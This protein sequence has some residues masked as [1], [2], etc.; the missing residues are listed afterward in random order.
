MNKTSHCYSTDTQRQFILADADSFFASCERVF[1]PSLANK[2]IVV[3][4]NNDG[5]VVAR[6]LEAKN[7]GIPRGIPWFKIREQAAH[8][9]V[10]ARSSNYELYASLSTRMMH[11]MN[12]FLP[13][14]HVY[15][16]DECFFEAHECE[17]EL[18]RISGRMQNAV[19]KGLGLP[20]SIS[21]APTLTLTKI[22][23]HWAKRT[24]GTRTITTWNQAVDFDKNFLEHIDVAH[25]WGVGRHL[26]P[27]L[28]AMGITTAADLRDTNEVLI[29]KQFNVNMQQT[30]L[31]LRGIPCIATSTSQDALD[32][33]RTTQIMCSR[34]FSHPIRD[35]ATLRQSISVYTQKAALRLRHQGSL[36][37]GIS[38]F[39]STSRYNSSDTPS[40]IR[41]TYTL[42]EPTNDPLI[43]TRHACECIENRIIIGAPYTRAGVILHGL[44]D[45]DSYTPL[46]I[47]NVQHD[48]GIGDI[49]E[50]AHKR[51]G[52]YHIGI[53]Y[54]GIRGLARKS[55]DTGAHW[56]MKRSYLSSRSTTCWN[57]MAIVRA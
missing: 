10:I 9:G 55:G 17:E 8:D 21:I 56:S 29:R 22:I 48:K 4:S 6:N 36:A 11:I 30:V 41:G 44:I 39:C 7:L 27:K 3:L 38:V 18:V 19:W 5:C 2:P 53:G 51:F 37:T 14:Q 49:L 28:I 45:E 52:A 12:S 23:N 47:F 50:A 34:M 42:E 26:A 35:S 54:G 16:I 13:H 43:L 57:E 33:K 40:H 32:G 46:D 1:H 15:S 24:F 20:I 25:V 31:E